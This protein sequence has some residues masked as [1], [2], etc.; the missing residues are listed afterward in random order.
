[1]VMADPCGDARL[2]F[3][4]EA[5]ATS[6]GEQ[7]AADFAADQLRRTYCTRKPTRAPAECV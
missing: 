5:F 6:L 2:L 4:F 3:T 1:M 7:V